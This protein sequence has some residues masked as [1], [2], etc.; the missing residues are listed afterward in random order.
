MMHNL[1]KGLLTLLFFLNTIVAYSQC[2]DKTIALVNGLIIDGV[3]DS[4]TKGTVLIC[5][6]RISAIG[7]NLTI[8]ANSE[9]VNLQG[10]AILP[11]LID[12]HGHLYVNTGR[13]IQNESSYLNLFLAG[14]VT[15]IYSP[16]EYDPENTLLLK[17]QV[18]KGEITGPD[19][20]TAGP[21]FDN[22]PSRINWIKGT[23]SYQEVQEQFDKW[24]DDIDGIK[25]YMNI[26][27]DRLQ[28]IIDLADENG[29]IVSGHLDSI[30]V[31][32]AIELGIDGIEHGLFGI[33]ELK[34]YG[35]FNTDLECDE[36]AIDFSNPE[37]TKIIEKISSSNIYVD[38]TLV[39]FQS[40]SPSFKPVYSDWKDF[41]TEEAKLS[42]SRI[43]A[44]IESSTE[45]QHCIST[46]FKNQLLFVGELNKNGALIVA[47]TDPVSPKIIPGYGLHREMELLVE[48]GLTPIEAIKAATK[49]AAIA[50]RKENDFGTIEVGKL[51][52]L[53]IVEGNPFVNI[54]DISNTKM[55][56]KRGHFF[57]PDS[58]RN[59]VIGTIGRANN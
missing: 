2:P 34:Q 51:A 44:H 26:T 58:L 41:L 50:L 52:N 5:G 18:T 42:Y 20:F 22:F 19:I 15:T 38:P 54:S 33:P 16:G 12:M 3:K 25:V 56:L 24:K 27:E 31:L 32:R 11:G 4:P 46:V 49:N 6:E 40:M 10:L 57:N 48:A 8:P 17:E 59:E 23:K 21:Y 36:I 13:K 28:Q 39:T 53:T 1:L 30:S 55:V 37:V 43:E 29:L 45:I 9:I 47:G 7:L 35:L 14:G